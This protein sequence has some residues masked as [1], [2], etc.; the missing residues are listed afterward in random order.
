ML[1]ILY[2]FPFWITG[3]LLELRMGV[4]SPEPH[5][6]ELVKWLVPY[7]KATP[8]E[9]ERNDHFLENDITALAYSSP[10]VK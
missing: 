3:S 1:N 10:H 8:E 9:E 5:N 2:I 4:L 7:R 6:L